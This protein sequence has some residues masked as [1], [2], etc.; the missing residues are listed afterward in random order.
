MSC[1][2]ILVSACL[3]GEECRYNGK[4][5]PNK[6][7]GRLES[8]NII[9]V[10]PE[11]LGGLLIPREPCEIVNGTAKDVIQNKAQILGITGLDYTKQYMLGINETIKIVK[12][13][14]IKKAIL[15]QSSPS[16]GYGVIYDGSFSGRKIM[17]NGLLAE[18]LL[19]IG[20]EIIPVE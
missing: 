5:V 20:V 1:N 19:K 7:V 9:K 11:L 2:K 13:N 3:C 17:G 15:K 4:S 8:K 18:E 14:K 6:I 12:Q 16:C 10:C